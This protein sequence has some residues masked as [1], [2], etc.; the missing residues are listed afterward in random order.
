MFSVLI[1]VFTLLKD[2]F[3]IVKLFLIIKSKC[4]MN[5]FLGIFRNPLNRYVLKEKK[6]RLLLILSIDPVKAK[7]WQACLILY[8]D[9]VTFC[10]KLIF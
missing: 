2:K 5:T 6:R 9:N 7:S 8:E 1:R 3:N 4:S 10:L